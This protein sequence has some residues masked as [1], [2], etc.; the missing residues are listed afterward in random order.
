MSSRREVDRDGGVGGK[1]GRSPSVV[2]TITKVVRSIIRDGGSVV[3]WE[4]DHSLR[5]EDIPRER[6]RMRKKPT[7]E[8]C[9]EL[10]K[11]PPP[12]PAAVVSTT[13]ATQQL[14]FQS[15]YMTPQDEA[16]YRPHTTATISTHASTAT[17]S[18]TSQPTTTFTDATPH[19]HPSPTR[20]IPPVPIRILT[21]MDKYRMVRQ[22]I[23][24]ADIIDHKRA[25]GTN[26]VR[27]VG[28]ISVQCELKDESYCACTIQVTIAISNISS[29]AG[30]CAVS[31]GVLSYPYAPAPATM[32]Q[33]ATSASA[34]LNA[35]SPSSST[36]AA[37]PSTT[38]TSTTQPGQYY[39]ASAYA[40]PQVPMSYACAVYYT[41]QMQGQAF[42]P[43]EPRAVVKMAIP[44]LMRTSN[45]S[46]NW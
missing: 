38:A 14:Y 27:G 44:E 45:K 23:Y 11:W 4:D 2:E 31:W 19:R 24:Q 46:A 35:Q 29:S 40:Y 30:S 18:T 10:A 33:A 16:Y 34:Q 12:P 28:Q 3:G 20:T 15:S 6:M 26:W 8:G 21:R 43:L 36:Q 39:P 5:G 25:P 32:T 7:A 9:L 37:Q 22:G 17:T 1:D 42:L 41:P 13:A